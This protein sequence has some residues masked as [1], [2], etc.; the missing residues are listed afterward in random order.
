MARATIVVP[1]PGQVSMLITGLA[2][3]VGI[4]S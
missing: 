2:W 3:P 1:E 4:E